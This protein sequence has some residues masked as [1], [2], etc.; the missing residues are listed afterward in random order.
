VRP[1]P[2]PAAAP[3]VIRLERVPSTQAVAFD[4]AARGAVDRTV[5]VAEHQTAGRGRGGRRWQDE[6]G[7]N[8]LV[9]ILVRPRLAV[10]GLPLL[11]YVAAIATAEALA[12]VTR[13]TPRLKWPNDVLVE[14]RKIAGILLESRTELEPVVVTGIGANL[15]Q[16][17]FPPELALRATS[18]RLETGH[19]VDR[20]AVLAALLAAFDGWRSRLEAE[21]FGPVRTRWLALS[22]TIGRRVRVDGQAGLA[23]DL[24]AGGALVLETSGGPRRVVAGDVGEP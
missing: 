9:S 15:N 19:P 1:G 22:D 24:D 21:G 14:G 6:P 18:A 20:E 2:A 3:P 10:A 12:T 11:S 16:R 13:L 8:L 17:Q 4:L 7:A 23:V 5:V